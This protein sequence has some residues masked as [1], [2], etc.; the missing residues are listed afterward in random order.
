LKN[1]QVTERGFAGIRSQ[2]EALGRDRWT[3]TNQLRYSSELDTNN[4]GT[5]TVPNPSLIRDYGRQN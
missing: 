2:L 4:K 5:I 1:T 3:F